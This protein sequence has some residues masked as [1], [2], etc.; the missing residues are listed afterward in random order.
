[1]RDDIRYGW[2]YHGLV[3]LHKEWC[4]ICVKQR[5]HETADEKKLCMACCN[6]VETVEE[7]PKF[8]IERFIREEL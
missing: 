7:T 2:R 1:M 3:T 6:V 5:W 4:P 8:Q